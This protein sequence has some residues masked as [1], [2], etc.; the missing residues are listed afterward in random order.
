MKTGIIVAMQSEFD[1]V[2]G[3]LKNQTQR[4]HNHI[5]FIEGVI[6]QNEIVLML[7]ILFWPQKQPIMTFGAVKNVR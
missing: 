2:K 5:T 3:I 7:W 4:Q 6:E 1:L